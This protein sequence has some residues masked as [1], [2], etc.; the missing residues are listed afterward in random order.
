MVYLTLLKIRAVTYVLFLNPMIYNVACFAALT[1]NPVR[2]ST[3]P[4][5]SYLLHMVLVTFGTKKMK[6]VGGGLKRSNLSDLKSDSMFGVPEFE[7]KWAKKILKSERTP[8]F[9]DQ[10]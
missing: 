6:P 7:G 4:P 10:I 3:R 9:Q 2:F 1:L 8:L 5:T